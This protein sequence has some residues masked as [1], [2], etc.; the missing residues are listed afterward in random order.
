MVSCDSSHTNE[1]KNFSTNYYGVLEIYYYGDLLG[2]TTGAKVFKDRQTLVVFKNKDFKERNHIDEL[3]LEDYNAFGVRGVNLQI[4]KSTGLS[5]GVNQHGLVAV[6][7]N[8]LAT[9]DS[10][11]DLITERI[12]LEAKTIDEAVEIC[13]REIRS[14]NYQ[15]CNM[16]VATPEQL[17]ALEITSSEIATVR[18]RDYLVRT[19]HHLILDTNE[20]LI[21]VDPE[22]EWQNIEHSKIRYKNADR[23]LKHASDIQ[24]IYSMLASHQEKGSIC[25]HGTAYAQD[26]SYTSVYSYLIAI[27][28]EE[29]PKIIFNVSKG[30]P[31]QNTYVKFNLEF[32]LTPK[33]NNL[34]KDSFPY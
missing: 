30:P 25:R 31:C 16:V 4:K 13:E 29:S 7:S 22:K 32:P 8:I 28:I 20:I 14:T 21:N 23:Y 26:L 11:Y 27:N 2:C 18:S 6:N 17:I 9:P 24:A 10:P 15:W 3:F 34:I 12:V 5:I 1:S 33:K 19:N